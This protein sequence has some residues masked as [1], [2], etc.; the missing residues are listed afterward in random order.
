MHPVTVG[1]LTRDKSATPLPGI[2]GALANTRLF[3]L[4][5]TRELRKVAKLA[6]IRRIPKGTRLMTE[7]DD[8]DSMYVI[9]TGMARVSRNGRRVA[10]IGGGDAVGELA[11]LARSKRN[12][13]VDA[14][15][16]LEVAEISRRSLSRLVHDVPSFSLKLLEAMAA[17]VRELDSRLYP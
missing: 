17:R 14:D 8:G 12:A 9:L 4:C 2:A 13:T 11:L 5:S 10:L 15:S 7:G 6:K 3:S 16:D 1:A